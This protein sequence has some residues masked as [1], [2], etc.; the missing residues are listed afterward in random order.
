MSYPPF[1]LEPYMN[2]L[3]KQLI[4]LGHTNPELRDHLRPVLD[5]IAARVDF[6]AV[7]WYETW[8][9]GF[10][11]S[12]SGLESLVRQ[13][14]GVE[15][16]SFDINWN[17]H[18]MLIE[19]DTSLV[20]PSKGGR[21]H[22][23]DLYVA[24]Y[25]KKPEVLTVE[26][27]GAKDIS[28]PLDLKRYVKPGSD[29]DWDGVADHVD[30]VLYKN[31][32]KVLTKA[33]SSEAKKHKLVTQAEYDK[34]VAEKE[35]AESPAQEKK[36]RAKSAPSIEK[37]VP[38]LKEALRKDRNIYVNGIDLPG[39]GRAE[40]N[41]ILVDFY[42]ERVPDLFDD[43]NFYSAVDRANEAVEKLLKAE[44]RPFKS[45]I[46]KMNIEGDMDDAN[47]FLLAIKLK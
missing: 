21:P 15:D 2:K 36:E 29:P 3:A 42:D 46:T 5:K 19:V 27:E 31:F 13:V 35:K 25:D 16:L 32:K 14:K 22:S 8:A 6:G 17:K 38:A 44:L 34:M 37:L 9:E 10:E 28:L 43:P 39:K 24:W 33:L 20:S 26:L 47:R 1:F 30:D 18:Y 11:R 23:F 7:D 45:M 41:E 40:R 4:K 12:T